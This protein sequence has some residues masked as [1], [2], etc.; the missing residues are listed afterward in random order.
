MTGKSAS[1]SAVR[2]PFPHPSAAVIG[3]G[4][5]G[6]V[7]ATHLARSG[8]QVTVFE[9]NQRPGG[10]CDRLERQGHRFDTGPTLFIMPLVYAAELAALGADLESLLQLQRVDPTYRLV[11]DDGRRLDL[12][13]DLDRMQ[14]QLESIEP[15]SF[16]GYLEYLREGKRHYDLALPKLVERDFRHAWEF[17]QPSNIPLLAQVRPLANHYRHMNSYVSS[18]RLKAALTFQDVYMGLSPFEAPATFSMMPYTEL[19][20]GVWYPKGGMYSVIEALFAIA[21]EAGVEF[22]FNEPVSRIELEGARASGLKLS[23]GESIPF[24]FVVANADLPYA[25][26][27][28]LPDQ[29][30]SRNLER[31]RYSCSVIS[32]FWGVDTV[33]ESLGPHTLFLADDYRGN[34]D[35]LALPGTMPPSPSLYLH[36]PA[37]LDPAMAPPGSDTLIAIVPVAHLGDG[38]RQDV[39]DIDRARQ[40]VF[41]RLAQV[42]I[43]DL[44]RHIKFET[45][46]TPRSWRKRYNLVKGA[47]HGLSHNLTQLAYFRPS[48]RHPFYPNLYFTGASTRPGTGIPTCMISGRLTARR[49][50]DEHG[51]IHD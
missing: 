5:G 18:P 21:Q 44:G 7:A 1:A 26:R 45:C 13:S 50:M 35:A 29:A 24:D 4:V 15:G 28:L 2:R 34:F 14:S 32:F 3:A 10:R 47:T 30:L 33:A 16:A 11:F 51:L 9:K 27:E 12:T 42:G 25:Y 40:A 43:D 48:N 37:R 38:S 22:R 6:L 49:L 8:T 20:H 39:D 23:S 41:H 36:A 46:F 17:F 19:A 31:K